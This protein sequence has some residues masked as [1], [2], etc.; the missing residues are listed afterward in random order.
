[1]NTQPIILIL[2]AGRSSS[3]LIDHLLSRSEPNGWHVQLGDLNYDL[4]AEKI[5]DHPCGEAFALDADDVS[6]RDARIQSADLVIS[7]VPAFLHA[8]IAAVAI[9]AG[10]PVITPSYINSE[11]QALDALARSKGVLVLNEVGLDPGI[12]HLSAMQILDQIR[13]E[14]GTVKA[15]ESYCG[16]LIAPDSDTNPWH[17]KFS[18]NPR[19][20]VL[21][22]QG[23]S[24]TFIDGG[25]ERLVAPHRA[26][27]HVRRMEIHGA[28]YEG[29]PNRDSLAYVERYGLENVETLIR[30][31]LR[32]D[33]FCEAWD[34]LVQ[35]GVV[36]DDAVMSWPLGVSWSQWLRTFLPADQKALALRD[37]V[38]TLT[39]V[40]ESAMD[41]LDWLGLFDEKSGPVLL[42]GT[43]AQ[44]MQVLLESKWELQP[45]DRDMVI[46]WHRFEYEKEGKR[47]EITSSLKLEG[48]NSIFTAMSDTVGWP[49]AIAAEAI[50]KKRIR[51]I[52]VE[53]PLHADYYNLLLPELASMGVRFHE[54]HRVLS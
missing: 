43:P 3:S 53:A 25:K 41:R 6:A 13:S 27:H 34:A 46:M 16:G 29:Y 44:V 15:F 52:G 30:G 45:S 38:Q 49:M 21:A 9:K 11:M 47:H 48:R 54:S 2:G 10:K 14:G 35:L 8:A 19:N 28:V 17:Y 37:V 51:R 20:V 23:G 5:G 7:M 26:F 36:R 39:G 31:T 22:G 24:A 18:W 32:G 50:L 42:H 1:M 12:D 33:G 4:A 40:S